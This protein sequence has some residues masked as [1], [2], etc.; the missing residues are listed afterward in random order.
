MPRNGQG[1]YS[2]PTGAGNPVVSGTPILTSWANLTLADVASALTM[3]VSSDGQTLI[4]G[5]LNLGNNKIINLSPGIVPTDGVNL[6]QQT[7]AISAALSNSTLILDQNSPI[8]TPS[9]L[10][11]TTSGVLNTTSFG[12][13]GNQ[14][15]SFPANRT[16]TFQNNR[17]NGQVY[18]VSSSSFSVATTTVNFFPNLLAADAFAI[19][20]AI[21]YATGGPQVQTNVNELEFLG[22]SVTTSAFS[23]GNKATI[24]SNIPTSINNVG[25]W[26]ISQVVT[27]LNFTYNG[28]LMASI[29]NTGN[30]VTVANVTASGT[31]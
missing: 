4:T 6:A 1:Q 15:A 22:L 13:A 26:N 14:T 30:I 29:S 7:S 12:I 23:T 11:T 18:S 20:T 31:P 9:G 2:V 21:Y 28:T 5:A 3:S 19:G 24:T 17:F 10:I 8:F 27:K 25:G 16:F